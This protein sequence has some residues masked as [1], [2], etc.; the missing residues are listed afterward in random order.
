MFS[1][2]AYSFPLALISALPSTPG[3]ISNFTL[4]SAVPIPTLP[5]PEI[6]I[7]SEPFVWKIM[8]SKFPLELL[9]LSA[10]KIKFPEEEIRNWSTVD[11]KAPT[12][13]IPTDAK[14]TLSVV[15][16]P[17]PT[18]VWAVLF[19][20]NTTKPWPV[21]LKAEDET[22]P[23]GLV[24]L[25]VDVL[26]VYVKPVPATFSNKVFKGI[27][28]VELLVDPDPIAITRSLK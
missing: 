24:E 8:L 6:L 18:A 25:K 15:S 28:L 1:S 26:S 16:K 23:D 3:W 13:P 2:P 12:L 7:L 14:V 22:V 19:V 4:G 17:K 11:D 27:F 20:V 21:V 10:L 5:D 9:S